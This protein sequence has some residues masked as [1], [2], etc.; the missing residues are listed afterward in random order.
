MDLQI[1]KPLFR[2][3]LIP[4]AAPATGLVPHT[5]IKV[6][7]R[8]ANETWII[9]T[10]GCQYGFRDILIPVD[11]YLADKGCQAV[12]SPT[13]Y[14]ASKTTDLDYFDTLPFMN[15]SQSQ[16]EARALERE[17]RQRFAGF[18]GTRVNRDILAGPLG[19]FMAASEGMA[20]KLKLYM[21]DF[22]KM[23]GLCT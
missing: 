23:K 12:R 11:K 15:M 14:N 7:L 22:A 16:R 19:D 4:S 6:Q 10:T 13:P 8:Q 5:V 20:A 1:G 17:A 21:L 3:R 2:T 9:D 18:V